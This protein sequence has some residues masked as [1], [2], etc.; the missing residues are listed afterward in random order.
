MSYIENNLIDSNGN[1]YLRA[2]SLIEVNNKITVS[3]NITLRQ[4]DVKEYGSDKMH[5]DKDL[6]EDKP[7]QII[8]QFSEKK[9]TPIKFYSVL[10]K[11]YTHFMMEMVKY[12][13]YFLPVLIK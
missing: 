11:K 2:D 10:L 8:D 5:M 7:C 13:W 9:I 1:M 6:T 3:N 4:V 12:V